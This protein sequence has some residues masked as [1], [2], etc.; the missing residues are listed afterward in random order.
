MLAPIMGYSIDGAI[1]YQ[2]ESNTASPE[3][4]KSLFTAFVKHLHQHFGESTPVIFTQLANYIDPNG[5][6]ENWARLREQQKNCLSIPNT[7]MAVAIDCGEY[8]DLHPQDKKTVGQRLALC[9]R[10][11]AYNENVAYQGP[12]ATKAT[13]KANQANNNTC[14]NAKTSNTP[15]TIAKKE[16]TSPKVE[17]TIHFNNAEGLW[18]KNGRPIVEAIDSKGISHHLAAEIKEN[19]L[20]AQLDTPISST[21]ASCQSTTQVDATLAN[22]S[23]EIPEISKLRFGWMDCPPVVLYNAHNLPASP[24]EIVL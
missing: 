24:F 8:N 20:V 12:I 9:A 5:N 15:N 10:H 23:I 6:G 14:N 4:Y 18:A 2:G 7:A 22:V 11:L 13:I 1:W 19:T 21:E 16:P 3:S 17:I